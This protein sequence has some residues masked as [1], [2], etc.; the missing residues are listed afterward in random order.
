MSYQCEKFETS[1]KTAQW[2]IFCGLIAKAMSN[3]E[4]WSELAFI[5]LH[6]EIEK[7][8]DCFNYIFTLIK[9]M[10]LL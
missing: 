6:K 1:V 9:Y 10:I 7:K 5:K 4:G 3:K 2:T 8:N